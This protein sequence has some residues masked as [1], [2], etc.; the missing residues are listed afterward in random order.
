MPT[1]TAIPAPTP[2]PLLPNTLNDGAAPERAAPVEREFQLY[3]VRPSGVI[4]WCCGGP[5]CATTAS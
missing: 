2:M 1:G 5:H 3:A 4:A